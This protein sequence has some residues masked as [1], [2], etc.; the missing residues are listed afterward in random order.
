MTLRVFDVTGRH[1]TTLLER[2]LEAGAHRTLW[3]ARDNDGHKVPS[4][5]YVYELAMGA[6][7]DRARSSLRFTLGHTS[8]VADLDELLAAL[9]GAVERAR[10]A[11]VAKHARR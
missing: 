7:E 9:P 3:N 5:V 10:R 2:S 11:G 8:T 6:D 1:V 4:G